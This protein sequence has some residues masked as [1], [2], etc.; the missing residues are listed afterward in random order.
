MTALAALEGVDPEALGSRFTIDYRSVAPMA[1]VG[2]FPAYREA[3][4]G[5]VN[6]Q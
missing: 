6:A 5:L 4:L 2:E 3:W 1:G